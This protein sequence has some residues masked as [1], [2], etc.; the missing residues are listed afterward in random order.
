MRKL[1]TTSMLLAA[2]LGG[3]AGTPAATPA[4]AQTAAEQLRPQVLGTLPH[5][6]GAFTEGL[7]FSGDTLYESTG[8]VGRSSLRTGPAGARPVGNAV[9]APPLFGEGVTVL[10]PTLWQLTWQNGFAIERDSKTLAEKRRVAYQGEG[11]GL[12]HQPDGRLVMSNGSSKLTFRDPV[13]FA[14]TGEVS[15]GYDQLNELECVGDTVYANVWQ[16][17]TILRIDTT[18]GHVT[19][20][21]DA[22]GLLSDSERTGADVLNGIA[23]VPGTDEFLLTGKLWPKQFRVKFVPRS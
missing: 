22:S 13:S 2:V 21:I 20:V 5:D 12:C 14:V 8:L 6:T 4:P 23:A 3:C 18:T 11:W 9:L 16:T 19:G 15:V 1:I 10:G 17:D 7:E